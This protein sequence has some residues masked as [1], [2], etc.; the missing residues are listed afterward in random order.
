MANHSP[1]AAKRLGSL[2]LAANDYEGVC[3]LFCDISRVSEEVTRYRRGL[4]TS[5][6]TI[7]YAKTAL[8]RIDRYLKACRERMTDLN[9]G[10][11]GID[12][13]S[14]C[15]HS[16]PAQTDTGE[17]Y[18]KLLSDK[19]TFDQIA[20]TFEL[21]L[22]A[23]DEELYHPF[24]SQS[25]SGGELCVLGHAL[26]S[27]NMSLQRNYDEAHT[28]KEFAEGKIRSCAARLPYDP[29]SVQY[30]QRQ[31]QPVDI[32]LVA[33]SLRKNIIQ[34]EI[35][36]CLAQEEDQPVAVL[37]SELERTLG[38]RTMSSQSMAS[39]AAELATQD[40]DH[41]KQPA[42]RR[43]A[44][45]VS[46]ASLH[47]NGAMSAPLHVGS[48]AASFSVVEEQVHRRGHHNRAATLESAAHYITTDSGTP[49]LGSVIRTHG[50]S[51]PRVFTGSFNELE[52]VTQHL[53]DGES[54][55][56]RDFASPT[57]TTPGTPV[58]IPPSPA[59]LHNRREAYL[60]R[61]A[62]R[63]RISAAREQEAGDV[64]K[65]SCALSITGQAIRLGQAQGL[66]HAHTATA[67][68]SN[69]SKRRRQTVV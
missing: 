22:E 8:Q 17:V 12:F 49:Q 47:V 26:D 43:N 56:V 32:A 1:L 5:R 18:D 38:N 35:S 23:F 39:T 40:A 30:V 66:E 60:A 59:T 33:G 61:E 20:S 64:P 58:S 52:A 41:K 31:S 3:K 44:N 51:M 67:A 34:T 57:S 19:E 24:L 55:I 27:I 15:T 10:S 4:Q 68:R 54:V 46:T 11:Y 48:A 28:Y 69:S 2:K 45:T 50:R 7:G 42:T 14:R 62:G 16:E 63:Q 9:D 21:S 13:L 37:R 6:C 65:R 36:D 53:I 29:S 25:H